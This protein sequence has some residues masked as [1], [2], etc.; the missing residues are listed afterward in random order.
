MGTDTSSPINWPMLATL[1]G[2]G[3]MASFS[4]GLINP[5]IPEIQSTYSHLDNSE[6]LAQL[7]STMSAPIVVIVAPIVG[8]ML[9]KYRRKPIL[10]AAIIIYGIGTSIAFFLDSLYL[11]L[12]TR[13]L[14]GIAVATVMVTIPTLIADYYSGGRRETIMGWYSAVSAGAGA[15]AV[16]LGGLIADF[17]WR[18]LFLVYALALLLLPPVIRY[19]H[20]PVVTQEESSAS[21]DIGRLEAV[22]KIIR[23]SP[24]LLLLGIY[25]VVVFG[26][27]T[28]NLIQ[29]EVP[30]YLQDSLDISGSLTGIAL[31]AAMLAG[32]VAAALYGRIKSRLR[33]GTIVVIAFAVAS[34]GYVLIGL[35][36]SFA[37]IFIGI[38]IGAGG[39]GLI[40][41]RQTTGWQQLSIRSTVAVHSV[42]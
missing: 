2:I 37:L 34:V 38:V 29:I 19:L 7:V 27:L 33:H 5:N 17:N 39:L 22:R 35:T 21:D 26:Y 15:I 28:N 1:L 24:A 31:S 30:Y 18:Y 40:L 16:V 42:A 13:I 41:R 4:G 20:E 8:I 9:D 6:T 23:D 32:F 12:A 10:I 11:I 14:D 25:G 36:Q 3:V